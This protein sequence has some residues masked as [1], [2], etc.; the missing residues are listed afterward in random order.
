MGSV[1]LL[2][3]YPNLSKN[4]T[5]GE[6]DPHFLAYFKNLV[7][8]VWESDGRRI[9]ETAA[10]LSKCRGLWYLSLKEIEAFL[11]ASGSS[12]AAGIASV[13]SAAGTAACVTAGIGGKRDRRTA[14]DRCSGE[15]IAVQ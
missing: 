12:S 7:G 1:N 15:N 11:P 2:A 3:S 10:L 8:M 9:Q 5:F 6:K 4:A 13:A 14:A